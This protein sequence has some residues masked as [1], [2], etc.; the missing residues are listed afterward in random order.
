MKKMML[1]LAIV[2]MCGLFVSC[3]KGGEQG[4][5]SGSAADKGGKKDGGAAKADAV[6]IKAGTYYGKIDVNELKCDT[7]MKDMY[8]KVCDA[9]SK[10]AATQP[11]VSPEI[12]PILDICKE[13]VKGEI[14]YKLD[15]KGSKDDKFAGTVITTDKSKINY[16]AVF[17]NAKTEDMTLEGTV[18][19]GKVVLKGTKDE[20]GDKSDVT[21]ELTP[22]ADGFD[23]TGKSVSTLGEKSQKMM[24]QMGINITSVTCES[25]T[26]LTTTK[27]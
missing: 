10:E 19:G 18:E 26:K 27:P 16:S 9:V 11:V 17:N 20:D 22:T 14:D 2:G 8:Q 12:Q 4:K 24:A 6:D 25:S 7:S 15:L 21:L 3:N 13:E 5:D 23:T 1:V